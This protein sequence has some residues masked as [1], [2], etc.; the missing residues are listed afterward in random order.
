MHFRNSVESFVVVIDLAG[1]L[2]KYIHNQSL[3]E[4][5]LI[6]Q[7]LAT[8]L[9]FHDF[10]FPNHLAEAMKGM[11][12]VTHL[13]CNNYTIVVN[14]LYYLFVVCYYCFVLSLIYVHCT[15]YTEKHMS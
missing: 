15:E 6:L 13:P 1:A 14:F 2:V 3:D 8:Y 4:E 11:I 7:K 10:P 12:Y 5:P 9:T